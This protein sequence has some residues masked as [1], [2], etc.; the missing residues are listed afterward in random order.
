MIKATTVV[1]LMAMSG[2]VLAEDVPGSVLTASG[3]RYVLGQ[4]SKFRMDQYL[5]DTQT[6][7]MWQLTCLKDGGGGLCEQG[8]LMPVQYVSTPDGYTVTPPP[9]PPQR[10]EAKK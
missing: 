1:A 5:L 8:A 4:L 3:G 7:R 2:A 9:A 10:P 6:G